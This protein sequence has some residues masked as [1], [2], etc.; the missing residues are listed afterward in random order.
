MSLILGK[1][2]TSALRAMLVDDDGTINVNVHGSEGSGDIK[3]RSDIADPATSTFL[4]CD[5]DGKLMIEATLELDDS[6]LAKEDTLAAL[7]A[8]LPASLGRKGNSQ[9]LS[10]TRSSTVGTYDLSARTTIGTF[11][12]STNLLCDALGKLQVDVVGGAATSDAT[13]A[14]QALQLAQAEANAISVANID[15][16][17]TSGAETT[18]AAAQQVLCYGEVTSGPGSGELHPIHITN[19]G[20]VEVEIA[21]FVKG[22][23]IMAA[24]FP[25]VI[26]SDQSSLTIDGAVSVSSVGGTV[27]V[28]ATALPL[29]SGASTET[30]LSA[31]NTKIERGVALSSGATN[32][33]A[34]RVQVFGGYDA[35]GLHREMRTLKCDDNGVLEVDR[36]YKKTTTTQSLPVPNNTCQ[37]TTPIDMTTNGHLAVY[38]TTDNTTSNLTFWIQYSADGVS[39]VQGVEP[40]SLISINSNSGDFFQQ[41]E[42]IAPYVR[43]RKCNTSGA[44]ET[45][46]INVTKA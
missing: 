17:I 10:T 39:W 14:N 18:L 44:A 19:A 35:G 36:E 20:D 43:F 33:Q 15:G 4:K 31:I 34:Q 32:L 28:S 9:S 37:T 13:A 6:G 41:T 12:T 22:Q 30:T 7:S 40:D 8:K 3:A 5:T 16:K 45:F 2:D 27:A 23:D 38:G 21:D 25:V 24:S 42:V 11:G 1:T 29:P 46:L 26:A